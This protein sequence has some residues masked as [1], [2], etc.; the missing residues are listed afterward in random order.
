M[1]SLNVLLHLTIPQPFLAFGHSPKGLK[2]L[3]L[4]KGTALLPQRKH[5]LPEKPQRDREQVTRN[6]EI[7]FRDVRDS[8]DENRPPAIVKRHGPKI[9]SRGAVLFHRVVNHSLGSVHQAFARVHKSPA[10]LS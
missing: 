8:L 5:P 7:A 4:V 9:L 2:Q 1:E 6:A 3:Q 10:I